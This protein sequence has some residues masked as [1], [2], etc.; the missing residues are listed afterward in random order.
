MEKKYENKFE[1]WNDTIEEIFLTCLVT[2]TIVGSF[3][4]IFIK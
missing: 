4:S 3:L 1:S 2:V